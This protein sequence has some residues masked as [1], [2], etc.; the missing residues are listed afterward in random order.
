MA[1]KVFFKLA[2]PSGYDFA[3]G[4]TINYRDSIGK[5]VRVPAF[6]KEPV[7]CSDSV[8]HACVKIND[9]FVGA[10]IPCSAFKVAGKPVVDDGSKCGFKEL[11]VIEEIPQERLDKLFGWKYAE[12]C[13]PLNPL[14]LKPPKIDA[15]IFAL[16]KN[17]ASVRASVWASVWD[18]VW[19][20]VRDSIWA[21][22]RAS[23]WDSEAAYIGSLFLKIRK[24][25]YVQHKAGVYPFQSC[26]D[27]LR[28]GLVPS[29]DGE[30]W[31][32]HAGPK[33][34]PVYE[35]TR[36]QLQKVMEE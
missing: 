9:C 23:V 6:D 8:L 13:N 2:M 24:W 33:A 34:L 22:V 11:K 17:W 32:L 35:V 36:E 3:T 25:K 29:F 12:A 31:R 1:K 5:T 27:M 21:S 10:K 30:K 19:D 26:V 14:K 16:L 7:L 28:L 18:S 20:S 4:N 15:S